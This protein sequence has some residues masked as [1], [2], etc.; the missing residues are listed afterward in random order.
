MAMPNT[1]NQRSPFAIAQGPWSRKRTIGFVLMWVAV[2]IFVIGNDPPPDA[3][4]AAKLGQLLMPFI[5]LGGGYW[6]AYSKKA[7]GLK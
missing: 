1:G 7:R 6:L 3:E 4:P 5:M 2:L